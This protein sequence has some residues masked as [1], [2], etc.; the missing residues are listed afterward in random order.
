MRDLS[1]QSMQLKLAIE[2]ASVH[3]RKFVE[4]PRNTNCDSTLKKPAGH[5][6]SK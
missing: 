6:Q 4:L 1:E 5:Y 3:N 2:E